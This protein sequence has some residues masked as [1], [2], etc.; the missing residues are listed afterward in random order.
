VTRPASTVPSA[1]ARSAVRSYTERHMNSRVRIHRGVRGSFNETTG[2]IGGM[3]SDT[4]LYE[5]KARIRNIIGAGVL[6]IGDGSIDTATTTI[7]IPWGSATPRRDDLVEVV[8]DDAD[9]EPTGQFFR[10]LDIEAGGLF[11]EARRMH[12]VVWRE[13]A[14]WER[15]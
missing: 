14:R 13:S 4:V 1:A 8:S 15:Q 3:S 10:V 5:G 9:A 11:G 2:L 7:S 12:A 6:A